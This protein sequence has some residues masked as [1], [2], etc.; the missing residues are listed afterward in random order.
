M[1]VF[2]SE[3]DKMFAL[4]I[5]V[6]LAAI[7][8]FYAYRWQPVNEELANI[9]KHVDTLD[10]LNRQAQLKIAQGSEKKL[11]QEAQRYQTTLTV[12]RQLVPTAN[13]VPT[14]LEQVSTAARRV[15]LDVNDIQPQPVTGGEQFDTYRY[16]LRV[17]GDFHALAEFFTNVGSLTRIIAPVNMKLQMPANAEY[18]KKLR[19]RKDDAIIQAQFDIQTY[20][21]KGGLTAAPNARTASAAT[22][23]GDNE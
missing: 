13:E 21:A 19:R 23:P 1:A 17:Y 5:A 8:G 6:A 12:M 10:V 22:T 20:V 9:Q 4:L 2:K 14:L 7:Y 15:G 11:L 18:A 3:R 16:T